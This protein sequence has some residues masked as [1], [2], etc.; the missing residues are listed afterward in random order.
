MNVYESLNHT[1]WECKYH[2]IFIP[3]YRRQAL[4]G[5]LRRRG[6][7]HV[8]VTLFWTRSP[9]TNTQQTVAE[10]AED[11]ERLAMENLGHNSKAIHW[12]CQKVASHGACTRRL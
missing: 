12:V 7:R 8:G 3:K 2:V 4:Y 6:K 11:P 1:K 5:S 9:T 10:A